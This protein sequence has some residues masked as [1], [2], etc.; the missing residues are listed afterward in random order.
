MMKCLSIERTVNAPLDVIWKLVSNVADYSRYAPNIDTSRIISGEGVGMV[1]ECTSKEGR[2]RELCTTWK[3]NDH[4]E[5]EV[6]TQASDYPYPFKVL[7]G[8]W[9]VE[10]IDENNT[11][12]RMVFNVDFKNQLFGALMYPLMRRKYMKICEQLMDNWQNAAQ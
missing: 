12:I 4:Y 3:D 10:K 11:T 5:F 6:Q 9:S 8:K 1:R 2:W 7:Q